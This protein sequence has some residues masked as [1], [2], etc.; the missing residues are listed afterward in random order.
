MAG[1]AASSCAFAS[2]SDP[3]AK[4]YD[5]NLDDPEAN[6]KAFIKLTGSLDYEPVY[7][8]VQRLRREDPNSFQSR[9]DT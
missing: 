5:L 6:L 7:D 9:S 3:H 8:L 1:L 4:K 2:A